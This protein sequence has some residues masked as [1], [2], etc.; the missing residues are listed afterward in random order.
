MK[1]RAVVLSTIL[2]LAAS[3]AMSQVPQPAAPQQPYPAARPVAQAPR[4]FGPQEPGPRPTPQAA[5][6]FGPHEPAPAVRPEAQTPQPAIP[7]AAAPQAP[8]PIGE[9][10]F[11]P[12]LVIQHKQELA[13]TEEQK[14]YIK[15]EAIAA[16]TRF[17]EL[18][19]Q[20]QDEVEGL[21]SLMKATSIDEQKV[22]AQMDKIL[23]LEREVKRT[24]MR[25]SIR[26]KNKLTPDQQMKLQEFRRH[27]VP[28]R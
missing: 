9:N 23:D 4:A 12:E 5:Q 28:P 13:L 6:A 25:L 21:I 14:A 8:D 7:H 18:Q 20:M 27:P 16:S 15:T 11:P 26:I 3:T 22:L 19:W 10:L 24:Q 2:V 17:N 1:L